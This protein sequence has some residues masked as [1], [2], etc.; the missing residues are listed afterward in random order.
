MSQ[1]FPQNFPGRAR[2]R[3]SRRVSDKIF[4]AFHQACDQGEIEVAK[5]L[6]YSLEVIASQN[7]LPS[8]QRRNKPDLMAAHRKI[9]QLEQ[10]AQLIRSL[11]NPS[12]EPGWGR[13][14]K[15]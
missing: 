8:D 14:P 7:V 3:Q 15:P 13:T 10:E 2:P 6:L 5:V 12:P 9:W 4:Q 1:N 11:L